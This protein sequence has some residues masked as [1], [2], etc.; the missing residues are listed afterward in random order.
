MV[1]N[2]A[3]WVLVVFLKLRVSFRSTHGEE[4]VVPP[5]SVGSA[6]RRKVKWVS[7]FRI[8]EQE[9]MGKLDA[10]SDEAAKVTVLIVTFNHVNYVA[11]AIESVLRQ[12][13]R[14]PVEVIVSEDASTDGTR[15]VVQE[16]ASNNSGTIRLI[17]SEKNL[18]SN[19]V[20]ARGL[21]AA[22]GQYVALLDGD[23]FWTSGSKIQR[24]VDFLEAHPECSA[25]FL[26]AKIAI[27]EEITDKSWTSHA[28]G[29]TI[30]IRE[31]W[32]GNPYATCGS[33]MRSDVVRSVPDWYSQFFPITD[34][35]LYILCAE[36]GD[37]AFIDEDAGVYR[38]HPGGQYSSLS[39]ERKL[40]STENFYR[41]MNLA[42]NFRHDRFARA[43]ASRYFFDWATEYFQ[44][45][46][47]ALARS[48]LRRC[49]RS[50][51]VG[52]EVPVIDVLRLGAALL[53]GRMHD[54]AL[55]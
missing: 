30:G 37:L 40:D 52:T 2:N 43:G 13:T 6:G 47:H 41:N 35:P 3:V 14:F 1:G 7:F 18:R 48:C 19:E 50:G 45:G 36:R 32:F 34:W 55:S 42:L 15:E 23:D 20:V 54:R 10:M 16:I 29:L 26:N 21:R 12:E 38:L 46:Q 33:M 31:I 5:C 17:L 11:T 49:V 9:G 27:G 24:Q 8:L 44:R 51:G 39:P 53:F 4:V 25:V 22:S 28:Q